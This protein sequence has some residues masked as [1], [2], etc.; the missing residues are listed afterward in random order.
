MISCEFIILGSSAGMPQPG[1]VNSGYVLSVDGKHYQFDCGG[2]VSAAFRGAGLNPLALDSIFISHTH[3]DHICELPLYIQMLYLA[4]RKEP[5]TIFMP[6]EAIV[7]IQDYFN[8]LYLFREK[9][10][11][12]IHFEPVARGTMIERNGMS[13]HPIHNSHLIGYTDIIRSYGFPNKMQSFS[14]LISVEGKSILYSA[15]LGSEKDLGPFMTDVDLLVVESTHIEPASL[16][17]LAIDYHVKK[18]VLTHIAEILDI[19][20]VKNAADKAGYDGLIIAEDG[21]RITL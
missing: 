15:D 20:A 9:L 3:P 16:F 6:E 1:R 12:E 4:G 21:L 14:Y 2:G 11:F 17:D 8:A 13:I 18:T 19:N 5:V 10:P 7:P